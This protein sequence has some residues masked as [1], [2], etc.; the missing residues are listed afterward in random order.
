MPDN[1]DRRRLVR[2]ASGVL[3]AG[4][5]VLVWVG[6]FAGWQWI[7]EPVFRYVHLGLLAVVA[8]E[9]LL[10]IACPLTL[11]EQRLRN[12]DPSQGFVAAWA[13]RLL[14]LDLPSWAFTLLYLAAG[15]LAVAA[16]A[17]A[18][19]RTFRRWHASDA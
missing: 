16:L 5:L 14:Y 17:V 2:A 9:S 11:L 13:G 8:L 3:L 19:P 10:G 1:F 7:R 4:G 18:P 15:G 6:A 12:L